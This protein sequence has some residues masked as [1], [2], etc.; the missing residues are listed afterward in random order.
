MRS[1][2]K[3]KGLIIVESP[4]K[5]KTIQKY[6]RG[7]YLVKASVGHI[8]DLPRSKLGVDLEK[9]FLPVYE[10]IK[11][12]DK[13]IAELIKASDQVSEIYLAPDPD[14]E[15]EAIAWHVA[16]SLPKTGKKL[17]RVLF[18][19]ITKPSI[20]EAM[21]HPLALDKNK[22]H[23]QQARRVLD[24]LVG[25]KI[26]PLLWDKVRRGLSAGR[27]QSVALKLVVEREDEIKR[28]LPE[29]YWTLEALFEKNGNP[30]TTRLVKIANKDPSINKKEQMDTLIEDLKGKPFTVV[31]IQTKERLRRALPPFITSKLQQDA[32]TKLG[33]SAKKTMVLAQQLYEGVD[34]DEL[35]THGL[36]TYIR[37]D[38]VRLVPEAITE[39]RNYIQTTYGK[40]Y[41]PEQPI[42]YKTKKS[43]QDAHEAIR[44]TNL[45]FIPEKIG[46]YM[47]PDQLKLYQLIWNRFVACQM[48]PAQYDQKSIDFEVKSQQ[49]PEDL[50]PEQAQPEH[51]Q[52]ELLHH[53]KAT[54]TNGNATMHH[55]QATSRDIN[56]TQSNVCLFRISGSVLKFAGFTAVYDVERDSVSGTDGEGSKEPENLRDANSTRYDERSDFQLPSVDLHEVCHPKEFQPEQHF[57]QAPPRYSDASLIKELEE[58]G[59]GRPS[60]YASILSNIQDREYA[61]K[62]EGRYFPTE[63]GIVVTNLLKQAFTQIMDVSFTAG[64]EEKLDEV[65]E[66]KVDWVAMMKE[67]WVPFEKTL[68]EAKQTMKN[69]KTQEIPTEYNCEKCRSVMVI[70]WGKMGQFLA[71]S[72]YPECKNTSEFKKDESGKI[73]ILPRERSNKTC[74]KCGAAMLIKSGKFGKFL[75]C[76]RFPDCKQTEALTTGIR[77]PVCEQGELAQRMSRFKRFFYSCNQYPKCTFALWDK[78]IAQPCPQCQY[79]I[80]VEKTL[81]REGTFI[82]CP[83]KDCGYKVEKS[84]PETEKAA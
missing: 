68:E 3:K 20:L 15:G 50:R 24:R 63:L 83:N 67:F 79:P 69:I 18:N 73:L 82:K 57:T 59:I 2:S 78:P 51:S 37:T 45:E 34:L 10:T 5:A 39:V 40:A 74:V 56:L 48:N 6:L 60:T 61:E 19:A 35:G 4:S 47:E 72:G 64:M 75:A 76:E 23:A 25:Y 7:E 17:H 58:K 16:E 13:I 65:E 11:G 53:V 41:L 33:F 77:C 81:K 43:A 21:K 9:N 27:V 46:R 52:P 80:L 8:K 62:R 26:S 30:F 38:S 49:H 32:A 29:E 36:V 55:V 42:F 1:A 28:F 54:E 66:G 22:Y 84:S 44:P 71:C 14:R 31:N 12:K 70:K